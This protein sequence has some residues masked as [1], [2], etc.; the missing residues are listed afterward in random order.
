MDS[1]ASLPE[2]AKCE[3]E[4]ANIELRFIRITESQLYLPTD[5]DAFDSTTRRAID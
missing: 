1:E 4:I 5:D 3:A 2:L